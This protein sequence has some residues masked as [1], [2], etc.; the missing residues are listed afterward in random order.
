MK[1][2]TSRF[3][4]FYAPLLAALLTTIV[5]VGLIAAHQ[6]GRIDLPGLEEF[7]HN[8]IDA[9][10]HVRGKHKPQTDDIVIV[11]F[12]DKLR[13]EAPDV[14]QKRAGWARFLDAL[15]KYE[16]LAVGIDAFFASPE[17]SLP[18]GV[19]DKVRGAHRALGLA[20]EATTTNPLMKQAFSALDA[21]VEAARGDEI[22][23]AALKRSGNVVLSV[24]FFLERGE[25]APAPMGQP[26]PIGLRGGQY[27]EAVAVEQPQSR[28]PP[29]AGPARRFFPRLGGLPGC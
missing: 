25:S 1:I 15:A 29:R 10:F 26:E 12:D 7:E 27:D 3:R 19:M 6:L 24:L 14:F 4:D 13:H 8:S 22:L 17:I 2:T 5:C 21:V 16:P 23:A 28:R 9:R 18:P 11:G 20:A